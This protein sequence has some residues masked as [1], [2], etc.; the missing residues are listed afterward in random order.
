MVGHPHPL[1]CET[2]RFP[3]ISFCGHWGFTPTAQTV[4]SH[5]RQFGNTF[6]RMN[7]TSLLNQPA[8]QTVAQL[9]LRSARGH[10]TPDAM[11]VKQFS[12]TYMSIHN[13]SAFQILSQSVGITLLAHVHNSALS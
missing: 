9:R 1:A 11:P 12:Q 4:R 13:L 5:F 6:I 3:K 10:W 7:I 8:S 2:E